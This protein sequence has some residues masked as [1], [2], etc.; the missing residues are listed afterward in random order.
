MRTSKKKERALDGLLKYLERAGV[1]TETIEQVKEEIPHDDH[2]I[3]MQAEAVLLSLE[4]P[5][6]FTIKNCKRCGESFGTN[7]RYVSYCS[8]TCRA[9][10]IQNQTGIR[11]NWHKPAEERW[12]SQSGNVEPPLTI[13]PEALQA[14]KVAHQNLCQ[15]LA[16]QNQNGTQNPLFVEAG[17]AETLQE[18]QPTIELNLA[19]TNLPEKPSVSEMSPFDFE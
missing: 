7:Y 19:L 2:A 1:S 6:R 16:L 13:P 5:A 14:M 15:L 12:G 10:A 18:I 8:D 9:K 4:K 3:S 11:W 17:Q